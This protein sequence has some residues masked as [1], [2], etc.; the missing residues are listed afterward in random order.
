MER[1]QDTNFPQL[2]EKETE[3]LYGGGFFR[4]ALYV[5]GY[6]LGGLAGSQ[7]R[8]LNGDIGGPTA[9]HG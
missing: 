5:I 9:N 1:L 2:T 7:V 3:E 6:V 8:D 4:D